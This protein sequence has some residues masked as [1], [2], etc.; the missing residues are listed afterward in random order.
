MKQHTPIAVVCMAITSF[1]V[2][3]VQ[4]EATPGARIGDPLHAGDGIAIPSAG[5]GFT[6]RAGGQGLRMGMGMGMGMGTFNRPSQGAFATGG[7]GSAGDENGNTGLNAGGADSA[8][9]FAWVPDG[10]RL[11]ACNTAAGNTAG[12]GS[13]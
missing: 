10:G 13:R 9:T 8:I 12:C 5:S 6:L 2:L 11:D 3:V 7:Q 4:A 1:T